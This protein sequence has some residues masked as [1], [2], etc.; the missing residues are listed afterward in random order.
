M[1]NKSIILIQEYLNN[2]DVFKIAKDIL[3]MYYYGEI[4]IVINN[5]FE[6]NE[7][8]FEKY[9]DDDFNE[10]SVIITNDYFFD[11]YK[12]ISSVYTAL[13]HID[14]ENGVDICIPF[15]CINT[16]NK[17]DCKKIVKISKNKIEEYETNL[18]KL[19]NK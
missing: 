2:N 10:K 16:E 7:T 15:Q 17:I 4:I 8:L 5:K 3:K 13:D 6:D 11:E 9:K 12:H 19:L 18:L 14:N 1:K